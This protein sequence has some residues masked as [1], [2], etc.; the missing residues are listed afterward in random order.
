MFWRT[1]RFVTIKRKPW[2]FSCGN[3][4]TPFLIKKRA[5]HLTYEGALK[6]AN[7]EGRVPLIN[8]QKKN[9]TCGRVVV[10]WSPGHK[11]KFKSDGFTKKEKKNLHANVNTKKF[12]FFN[13]C[14]SLGLTE[15]TSSVKTKFSS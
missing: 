5:L 8:L 11:G 15:M 2:K 12:R 14:L 1:C 3:D 6:G 13:K 4:M 7:L 10:W 9:P